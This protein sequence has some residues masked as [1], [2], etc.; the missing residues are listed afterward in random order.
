MVLSKTK[1]KG[2]SAP[3]FL[4]ELSDEAELVKAKAEGRNL[5]VV[6]VVKRPDKVSRVLD[7]H[8]V[9]TYRTEQNS[10]DMP[11]CWGQS[12]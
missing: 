10:M 1:A 11:R 8:S 2:I 5:A 9:L 4:V 12:G 3:S 6:G 7:L